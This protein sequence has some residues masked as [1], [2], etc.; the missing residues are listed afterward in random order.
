MLSSTGD[1]L[2]ETLVTRVVRC[3]KKAPAPAAPLAKG[4][5][6]AQPDEWEIELEDTGELLGPSLAQSPIADLSLLPSVVP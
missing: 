5:K 3:D 1:P 2:L 6:Q 4:K